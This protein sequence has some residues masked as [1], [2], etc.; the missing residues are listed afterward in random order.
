[1]TAAP[2]DP[3]PIAVGPFVARVAVGHTLAYF[4]AGLLA[5]VTMG[6]EER[7][8]ADT[9]ALLLRPV[10]DPLVAAG[11]ALQPIN[12]LAL[13]LALAPFRAVLLGPD[14]VRHLFALLVAVSLFS[15]QT[16]GPGNLEGLLYTRIPLALHLAG[17]PEVLGYAALAATGIVGWCRAPTRGK[18]RAAA[19]LVALLATASALGVLDALGWLPG[20]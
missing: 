6:Y 1:M 7:F 14:G 13:G 16:P 4:V 3:G 18:D 17:L 8:A 19:V 2:D 5:L 9:A 15:P 12:G 11:P 10:D 20:P